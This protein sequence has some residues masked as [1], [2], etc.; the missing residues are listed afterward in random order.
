M[1]KQA[2]LSARLNRLMLPIIILPLFLSGCL[3]FWIYY[4]DASYRLD[5]YVNDRIKDIQALA[6]APSVEQYFISRE[7]VRRGRRRL[8]EG[9]R[10]VEMPA[11]MRVELDEELKDYL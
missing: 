6:K 1:K 5:H 4:R 2:T 3:A 11:Q 7:F 9:G 10:S 8:D